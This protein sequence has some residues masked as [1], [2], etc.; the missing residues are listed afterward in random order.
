MTSTQNPNDLPDETPGG[1]TI[2]DPETFNDP[3]DNDASGDT[4]DDLAAPDPA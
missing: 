4:G 1:S 2:A 3:A